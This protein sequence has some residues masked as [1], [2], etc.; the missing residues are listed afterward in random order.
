[1]AS[2]REAAA[3]VE[4]GTTPK[5]I[6]G[7]EDD[8]E[9]VA[10]SAGNPSTPSKK[11][12]SGGVKASPTSKYRE[13]WCACC[14]RDKQMKPNKGYCETCNAD[15]E[16][17]RRDAKASSAKAKKVMSEAEKASK[18]DKTNS[19]L[20]DLWSQWKTE[21]GE[22]TGLPRIGAFNWGRYEERYSAKTGSRN[23]I[24][25]SG[26]TEKEFCDKMEAKGTTPEWA[27]AEWKRRRD[28]TEFKNGVCPDTNLPTVQMFEG[29]KEIDYTDKS[30]EK[31]VLVGTK[32]VKATSSDL[33]D[34]VAAV[35]QSVSNVQRASSFAA[36]RSTSPNEG[37]EAVFAPTASSADSAKFWEES[38]LSMSPKN[39]SATALES[40]DGQTEDG[41]V[42]EGPMSTAADHLDGDLFDMAVQ[43]GKTKLFTTKLINAVSNSIIDTLLCAKAFVDTVP[44]ED[45]RVE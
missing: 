10:S 41:A 23:E 38:A 29:P 42:A 39:A 28:G 12:K 32:D 35:S 21:A 8:M 9:E 26:V 1:M 25:K 6:W 15:I 14:N 4:L 36:F 7:S 11:E 30:A 45:F 20:H 22:S 16:A 3:R 18:K 19:E 44:G 37:L 5:G 17:M 13:A 27:K 31:V 33:K 2:S 40:K 43:A 24:C 34:Q